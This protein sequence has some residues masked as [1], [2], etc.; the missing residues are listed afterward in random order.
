MFYVGLCGEMDAQIHSSVHTVCT[1][2]WINGRVN[3]SKIGVC[4]K[5]GGWLD[6][7]MIQMMGENRLLTRANSCETRPSGGSLAPKPSAGN[8]LSLS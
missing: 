4:I 8:I 7:W 5:T 3:D 6:V 1:D 2:V